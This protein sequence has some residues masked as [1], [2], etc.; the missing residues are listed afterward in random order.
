MSPQHIDGGISFMLESRHPYRVTDHA[1]NGGAL[2]QDSPADWTPLK[3][4]FTG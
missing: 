4:R 1:L 3:R 2:Q